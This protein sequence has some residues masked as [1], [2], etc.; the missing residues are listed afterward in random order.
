M[1]AH[2][3]TLARDD[4]PAPSLDAGF[5][6]YIHW[7]FCLSKCPYCDFN[8]HV[9][10]RV[11]HALWRRMLLA[12]L[13][14]FAQETRGRRVES[15]FFG[16][17]TPSLMDAATVAALLERIARSWVLPADA[18]ITLEANPG[19]S[20]AG[21]FTAFRQAGINR[22]SLGV[23]A[24]DD[25][26]LQALGRRHDLA[27]AMDALDLARDIFPRTS[28][29][30]IYARPGQTTEDW[31]RELGRA[32]AKGTDHLSLYQLTIEEGTPFAPLHKKGL[33]V[34]PEED[35]QADLF[36][37]TRDMCE[38]AGLPAYEISNHA[39]PGQ[40][41]RHNLIYWQ[42]GDWLGVGPG[43]HGRVT[44]ADGVRRATRQIRAPSRWLD[45]VART[46]HGTEEHL[47]LNAE[48]CASEL[49][50]MGLRTERGIDARHFARRAGMSLAS[51]LNDGALDMMLAD[52][53]LEWRAESLC[54]TRSGTRV[55][56]AVLARLLA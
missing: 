36:D 35:M 48:E 31:R 42:G 20:D 41:C 51:A 30:L 56:N 14:H 6:I 18:E 33:L 39:R 10:G 34:L 45:A 12:E 27:E 44:G 32:L 25:A 54:A 53:F 15:I 19:A 37:L 28:F 17:G 55:L 2:P 50:M 23:Q 7:P 11:D 3:E 52:G 29:D 4:P 13:D 40:E 5:G 26:A 24:L 47:A 9:A 1:R 46:G 22:L 21:R 16:G 8:S 38:A 43:A 49:V